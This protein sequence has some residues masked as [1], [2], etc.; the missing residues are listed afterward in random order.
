MLEQ[1]QKHLQPR[2]VLVILIAV[3][4]LSIAEAYV[5]LFKKPLASYAQSKTTLETLELQARQA[6]PLSDQILRLEDEIKQL[7]QRLHGDAPRLPL[8]QMIAYVIGQLDSIADNHA[9]Q[10]VSV[11]PGNG[12]SVFM[13]EEIPFHIEVTGGYFDLFDWLREVEN[14]LGPMVVKRFALQPSGAD[15]T[16]RMKLTMTSYRMRSEDV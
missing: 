9:V 5:Y 14:T 10:L 13:F 15:K 1:L 8:N 7:E 6:A 3:T 16:R 12:T 11:Q 2:M 4:L